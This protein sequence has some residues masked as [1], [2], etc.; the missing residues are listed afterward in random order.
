MSSTPRATPRTPGSRGK[1]SVSVAASPAC[2]PETLEELA[3]LLA[4]AKEP[5]I[6]DLCGRTLGQQAN[7]PWGRGDVVV[8]DGMTIKKGS[9]ELPDGVRLVLRGQRPRLEGLSI[10]GN[11]RYLGLGIPPTGL[12][13]INGAKR[14]V[15]HDCNIVGGKFSFC[16]AVLACSGAS[17]QLT[18]CDVGG[19]KHCNGLRARGT[20]TQV[21]A[22]HCSFHS[23]KW[24]GVFL[25]DGAAVDLTSCVSHSNQG[26]G[27]HVDA[28]SQVYGPFTC[29]TRL[30]A[31]GCVAH[32]NGGDAALFAEW[33]GVAEMTGCTFQSGGE[34]SA[35][36]AVD[37]RGKGTYVVLRGCRMDRSPKASTGGEVATFSASSAS[38]AR[39]GSA[40]RKR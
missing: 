39:P 17:V 6:F 21:V 35:H 40:M 31:A 19:A 24:A 37:A 27:M 14:A 12:V 20:G 8:P 33:G 2:C 7:T 10:R 36:E 26:C 3:A 38:A 11:G 1:N 16:C 15:L 4:S 18:A 5:T 29:H 34:G 32:D 22:A 28:T 23:N 30:A 25:C 13:W 9:L